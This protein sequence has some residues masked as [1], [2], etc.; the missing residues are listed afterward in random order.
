MMVPYITS[1]GPEVANVATMFEASGFGFL[2][3]A[4]L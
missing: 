2:R 1:D 4:F 3:S